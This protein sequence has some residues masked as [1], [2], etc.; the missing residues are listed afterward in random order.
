M[1]AV[2]IIVVAVAI[3]IAYVIVVVF[4]IAIVVAIVVVIKIP[5]PL[6]CLFDCCI[7]A[8]TTV[9][10]VVI[11]LPAPQ[12]CANTTQ[13]MSLTRH[14]HD[15]RRADTVQCCRHGLCRVGNMAPTCRHVCRFGG[16]NPRHDADITNQVDEQHFEGLPLNRHHQQAIHQKYNKGMDLF[17]CLPFAS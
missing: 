13:T 14:Q 4:I 15:V 16:G 11:L 2:I 10:V 17:L 3:P 7:S 5:P 9:V 8:A 6:L 12:L 1:P